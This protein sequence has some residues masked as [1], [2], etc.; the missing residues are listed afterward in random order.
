MKNLLPALFMYVVVCII[1]VL[2]PAPEGYNTFFWKLIV[3]Q[4]YAIPAFIIVTIITV[5]VIKSNKAVTDEE[6]E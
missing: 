5:F 4:V 6:D 3:G 2:L 1:A